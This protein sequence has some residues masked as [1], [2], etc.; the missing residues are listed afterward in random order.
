[1]WCEANTLKTLESFGRSIFGFLKTASLMRLV[2][3][4]H[5]LSLALDALV[6]SDERNI[7]A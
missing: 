5:K 1:M 4:L 3:R 2:L 7:S 6:K